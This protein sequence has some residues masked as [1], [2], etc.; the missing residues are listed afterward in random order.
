MYVMEM[1]PK[2]TVSECQSSDWVVGF[3]VNGDGRFSDPITLLDDTVAFD[4]NGDAIVDSLDKE[5]DIK[6]YQLG[7]A[8][9]AAYGSN[10]AGADNILTNNNTT[11]ELDWT[12]KFPTST[13]KS[14][15]D[16]LGSG[17]T[18]DKQAL[19]AADRRYPRRV[20]FARDNANN[21]VQVSSSPEIYKPMGV[22]CPLDTT[23]T[24]YANNGCA[25]ATSSLVEGTH[26]GK[27]GSSALWFR[28]TTS[29]SN[30][31]N[32]AS[33]GNS[34][35]L[36]YYSPIDANADGIPDL[37]GQPL[38]VPVLQIHDANNTSSIRGDGSTQTEFRDRWIQQP[39]ADT[40]YNATFVLGN[41]PSRSDE[42][43]AGFQNFV[44]FSEN[45]NNRTAKISGS[46]I[47]LKRSSF[48]TGPISP[49]F[50][51]K[52]STNASTTVNDT[53]A[54]LSLF[55]YAL[56]TYPSP[57]GSGLL[58][59]YNA[60]TNRSWGFDVGLLSEQPDLF[61]QRFTLPPAGRPNEYFREVGSR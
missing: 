15:R 6:A 35:S 42:T 28:T 25:Y 32:N 61:A 37:N 9:I 54:N 27:K 47:Q 26:Y 41:S 13:D 2:L 12:T 3:D 16:R 29:T 8:I 22:N 34:E 39:N 31:S 45:W 43:S 10:V 18:G 57:N 33:Y 60:P 52:S 20:A 51:A 1:C 50:A 55:D 4:V 30:P 46:F 59:F 36:F 49:I 11:T 58:P 53:T 21:L 38:L 7:Q 17:D 40:I 48:A 19:V 56:D 5:K 44:R 24:T 14:I 23:G